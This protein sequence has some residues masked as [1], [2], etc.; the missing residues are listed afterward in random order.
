MN[1]RFE[2]VN[3]NF[4]HKRANMDISK[5]EI[6]NKMDIYRRDFCHLNYFTISEQEKLVL[7]ACKE[8]QQRKTNFA[9]SQSR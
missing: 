1:K 6:Q 5:K 4:N 8:T 9:A 3:A 2:K 7:R